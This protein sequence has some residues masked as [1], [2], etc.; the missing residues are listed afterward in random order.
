MRA[1]KYVPLALLLILSLTLLLHGNLPQ[2][3]SGTWTPAN[4]LAEA[5]SGSARPRWTPA[6]HPVFWLQDA[7]KFRVMLGSSTIVGTCGL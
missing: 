2:I 4:N 3:S 6:F 1:T 7:A 5:R